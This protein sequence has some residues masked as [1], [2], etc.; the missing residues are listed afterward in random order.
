VHEATIYHKDSD[1]YHH[2]QTI[3]QHQY[4]LTQQSETLER[5]QQQNDQYIEEIA[6][7]NTIIN[8]YERTQAQLNSEN[9]QLTE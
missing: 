8:Q 9:A 2:Q 3:D 1:I 6:N 4:N 5:L 7:L